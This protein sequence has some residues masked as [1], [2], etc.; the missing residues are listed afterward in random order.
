M[1]GSQVDKHNQ[2]LKSSTEHIDDQ[3]SGLITSV[4]GLESSRS[5]SKMSSILSK[6]KVLEGLECKID[7]FFSEIQSKLDKQLS[8]SHIKKIVDERV[9]LLSE[10]QMSPVSPA[11]QVIYTDN[12]IGTTME[13][14]DAMSQTVAHEE[15][16][17]RQETAVQTTSSLATELAE[18]G[19]SADSLQNGVSAYDP[20]SDSSPSGEEWQIAG[21]NRSRAGRRQRRNPASSDNRERVVS[22]EKDR[23]PLRSSRVQKWIHVSNVH[24]DTSASGIVDFVKRK[25]GD[26]D[27]QCHSLIKRGV[28]P[29][30]LETATFRMGVEEDVY[31]RVLD[32]SFWPGLTR[33][34]EFKIRNRN[35]RLRQPPVLIR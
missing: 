16:R 11:Q 21:R 7:A 14:H 27:I 23:Q 20:S 5:D 24:R 17:E 10:H 19:Y 2:L 35:F 28:D 29:S 13:T 32:R 6:L 3:I 25:L 22:T 9:S 8:E 34:R 15:S 30:T 1:I 33:V 26:I 4:K 31:S 12:T 18:S